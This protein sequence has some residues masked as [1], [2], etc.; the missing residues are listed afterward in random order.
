MAYEA[1]FQR[2]EGDFTY[3]ERIALCPDE[4]AAHREAR[5]AMRRFRRNTAN[6][7][8]GPRYIENGYRLTEHCAAPCRTFDFIWREVG[9][10]C[11]GAR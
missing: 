4:D 11:G 7:V 1:A 2:R 8:K 3:S 5:D 9:Q 6:N 10:G